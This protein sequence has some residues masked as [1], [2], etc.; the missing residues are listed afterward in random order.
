MIDDLGKYPEISLKELGINYKEG[1]F[2]PDTYFFQKGDKYSS[3]LLIA[4]EKWKSQ[5]EI[6][7]SDRNEILPYKNLTEAITLASIIEK[8]GLEKNKIAGVFINR[9]RIGMKLQSD[10]TVI[11]ALGKDFDGDIKRKDL[12]IDNPYNTYRYKGFLLALSL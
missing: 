5:S 11:Y 12:R 3:I 8:E 4:Q 7:W 1:M 2:Y 10:P 6:L 9:L